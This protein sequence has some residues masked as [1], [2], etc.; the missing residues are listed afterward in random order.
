MAKRSAGDASVGKS[1]A[2]KTIVGEANAAKN[3]EPAA[4]EWDRPVLFESEQ[5][6][7]LNGF[8]SSGFSCEDL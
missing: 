4:P 3:A 2:R 1:D 6:C 5:C 8:S 7:D